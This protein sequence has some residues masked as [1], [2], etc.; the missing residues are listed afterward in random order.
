MKKLSLFVLLSSLLSGCSY[1][2]YALVEENAPS[3]LSLTE[4]REFESVI[5]YDLDSIPGLKIKVKHLEKSWSERK[6]KG[7]NWES[8]IYIEYENGEE[9]IQIFVE[10][11]TLNHEI[12]GNLLP[13]IKN[14]TFWNSVD[15]YVYKNDSIVSQIISLKPNIPRNF[16]SIKNTYHLDSPPEEMREYIKLKMIINGKEIVV[17][18]D[19][20]IK[21]LK[22]YNI[23]DVLMSV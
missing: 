21:Y 9:E 4:G 13:S 8:N 3:T 5:Y 2:D 17:K 11:S 22:H 10:E 19:F 14:L 20:V 7:N 1:Y 15:E 18:Y 6:R 12:S 23:I 16:V